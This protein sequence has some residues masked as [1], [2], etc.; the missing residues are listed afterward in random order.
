MVMVKE[1]KMDIKMIVVDFNST[2]RKNRN[3]DAVFKKEFKP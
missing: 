2:G 1:F 3:P